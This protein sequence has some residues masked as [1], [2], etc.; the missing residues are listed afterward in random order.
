M[1][2]CFYVLSGNNNATYIFNTSHWFAIKE[3]LKFYRAYTFKGKLQKS[4]L[5]YFLFVVG[6]FFPSICKSKDAITIYL[7][8]HIKSDVDFDLDE[9]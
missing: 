9:N 7:K 8:E 3:S 4:I 6:K 5:T 2:N 1:Y